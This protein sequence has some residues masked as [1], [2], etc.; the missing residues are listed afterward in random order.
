MMKNGEKVSITQGGMP[1]SLVTITNNVSVPP[2]SELMCQA[3]VL[4]QPVTSP[5]T[6]A[7]T[8]A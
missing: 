6:H 5:G 8:D 7:P 2:N 3:H 1:L 4:I